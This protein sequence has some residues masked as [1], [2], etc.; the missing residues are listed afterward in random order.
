MTAEQFNHLLDE[1]IEAIRRVLQYK[2]EEY[3]SSKDRL[4]NF[5]AAA[6][7]QHCTPAQALLG[8]LSKHLVSV[9]DMVLTD[10]LGDKPHPDKL[11]EKIGDAINYLILLEAIFKE[12]DA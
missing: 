4:H 1:R 12:C 6:L 5:K 7:L 10:S 9:V 2:A 11:N 8:M 3:A